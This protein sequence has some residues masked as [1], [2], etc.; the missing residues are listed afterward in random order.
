MTPSRSID[1]LLVEDNPADVRLMKE[2]LAETGTSHCLQVATDGEE[3]MQILNTRAQTGKFPDL[4]VLDLNLPRM[5][6]REVL[7][8]VKDSPLLKKIPV[9]ILTTSIDADDIA[10]VYETSG[11]CYLQKPEDFDK[12]VS[13]VRSIEQFWLTV[14]I[15]PTESG[16]VTS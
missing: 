1:I 5:S 10:T 9:I 12:L 11:N 6:G 16:V 14:V 2:A 7:K 13:V 4:I 8:E 3:A 15:L